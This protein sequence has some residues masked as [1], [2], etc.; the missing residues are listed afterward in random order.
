MRRTRSAA[1]LRRARRRIPG[2]VN[3][4][5]RAYGAV[6]GTPPFVASGRG[7]YVTDEDGNRY[8]DYV[9]SWGP[10]SLG[11]AHPAVLRAVRAAV[12]AGVA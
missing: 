11:H 12:K 3:S 1:L 7:A 9:G 8:V 10:L 5:V 4:P 6:G 2:G